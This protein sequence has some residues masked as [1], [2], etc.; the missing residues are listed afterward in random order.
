MLT[1]W[2]EADSFIGGGW[3]TPE[4]ADWWIERDDGERVSGPH[5]HKRA[6]ELWR[7]TYDTTEYRVVQ[8]PTG[9]ADH[10]TDVLD[11]SPRGQGDSLDEFTDALRTDVIVPSVGRPG[12]LNASEALAV[13]HWFDERRRRGDAD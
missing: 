3:P 2:S 10:L 9:D 8:R 7:G 12:P 4:S 11:T 5:L 13:G 6:V 1:M